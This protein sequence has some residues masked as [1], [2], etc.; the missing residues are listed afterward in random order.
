MT[1]KIKR[2]IY[3]IKTRIAYSRC[4]SNMEGIAVATFGMCSGA[5]NYEYRK[6]KCVDCPYYRVLTR[7][8]IERHLDNYL[9]VWGFRDEQ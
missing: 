7:D 3:K 5:F 2:L 1:D 9:N 8:E 4:Y 6:K